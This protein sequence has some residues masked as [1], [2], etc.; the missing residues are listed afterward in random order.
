MV[1]VIPG[2]RIHKNRAVQTLSSTK[3][4][5]L[6]PSLL[7]KGKALAEAQQKEGRDHARLQKKLQHSQEDPDQRR[8]RKLDQVPRETPLPRAE[9]RTTILV[10]LRTGHRRRLAT[11]R[12]ETGILLKSKPRSRSIIGS[13]RKAIPELLQSP[14]FDKVVKNF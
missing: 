14:L 6:A 4:S 11:M 10:K 2:E 7:L 12:L 1:K 3:Q 5:T 13:L 9:V 8:K